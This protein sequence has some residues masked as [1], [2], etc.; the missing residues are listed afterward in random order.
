M[1]PIY[2]VLI[3]TGGIF[4]LL[5][6]VYFL[7]ANEKA[8]VDRRK[9]QELDRFFAD[10]KLARMDYSDASCNEEVYKILN[11][12]TG[13]GQVTIDE[14]IGTD[15]SQDNAKSEEPVFNKIAN[16]GVEEITGN[17]KG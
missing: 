14:V 10:E 11:R 3:V 12:R 4:A 7:Y 1:E 9:Q 16:E 15:K 8:K 17:F 13:S 6:L 5:V 2:I